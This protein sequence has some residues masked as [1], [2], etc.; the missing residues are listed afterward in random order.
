MTPLINEHREQ[1]TALCKKYRVRS[2]ELFGSAA[3]GEFDPRTSDVDLFY[4]FDT[5]DSVDLA[6][7]FFGLQRDLEQLL[8]LKI[9]L[10]SRRDAQ[11]PYF[12]QV[13]NRH[14][15]TLYAA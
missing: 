15:V 1:I 13:A 8:G 5:N 7:R 6:D 14:C 2:L 9:D 10:I 3:S 4:E 12:L 11:N